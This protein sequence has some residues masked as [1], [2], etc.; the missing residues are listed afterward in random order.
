MA[1]AD[2]SIRGVGRTC[3]RPNPMRSIAASNG[4]ASTDPRSSSSS[5]SSVAPGRS[6]SHSAPLSS[7]DAAAGLDLSRDAITDR[8][9]ER[10]RPRRQNDSR[11]HVC[12]SQRTLPESGL[13]LHTGHLIK[14]MAKVDP[15]SCHLPRTAAILVVD[16][17]SRISH[18]T[19]SN[20][21]SCMAQL[22][23]HRLCATGPCEC[24]RD[25]M[26]THQKKCKSEKL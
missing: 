8:D 17:W 4:D 24:T 10:G 20:R 12:T 13:C 14:S 19:G 7:R 3:A 1:H 6:A 22:L 15:L 2:G 9:D 5:T 18:C 26:M 23:Q 21:H 25:T 11:P 16:G